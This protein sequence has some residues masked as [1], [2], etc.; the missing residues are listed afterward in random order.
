MADAEVLQFGLLQMQVCVPKLYSND[1]V[2]TFAN[3]KIPTGIKS[4]WKCT[5]TP[6][7]QNAYSA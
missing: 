5:K 7:I 4:K 1:D 2:E 6:S 3:A